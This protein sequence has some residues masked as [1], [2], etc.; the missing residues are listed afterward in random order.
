MKDFDL[1]FVTSW[2]SDTDVPDLLKIDLADIPGTGGAYVLG[3]T[4]TPLVY[5]WGTSPAYYVGQSGNLR[6]RL[7][8]HRSSILEGRQ[9]DQHYSGIGGRDTNTALHLAPTAAGTCRDA[10]GRTPKD[11]EAQIIK[12]FYWHIGST[13]VANGSW[14]SEKIGKPESGEKGTASDLRPM[15]TRTYREIATTELAEPVMYFHRRT[16]PVY[17]TPHR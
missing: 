13:P 4:S 10:C 14:A 17:A 15:L 1:R 2:R 3:T 12:E 9:F 16:N 7:G 8:L 6:K 11:L 5:A